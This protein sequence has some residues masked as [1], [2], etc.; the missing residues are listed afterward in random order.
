MKHTKNNSA[1]ARLPKYHI[2]T[3]WA[4]RSECVG[5][6]ACVKHGHVVQSKNCCW[7]VFS[8]VHPWTLALWKP[9]ILSDVLMLYMQFVNLLGCNSV[10]LMYFV[11]PLYTFLKVPTPNLFTV[12]ACLHVSHWLILLICGRRGRKDCLHRL[13]CPLC[14]PRSVDRLLC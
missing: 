8:C 7:P 2:S 1:S 4:K 13:L 6:S 5:L 14:S 12:H 10:L 9:Q 11:H 3:A